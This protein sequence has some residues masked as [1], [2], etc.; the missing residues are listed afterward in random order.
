V[1]RALVKS[2]NA[3]AKGSIKDVAQAE[4]ISLAEAFLGADYVVLLDV[5]GSMG[6]RDAGNEGREKRHDVAER[7]LRNLQEKYPG[8]LALVCFS[9]DVKFC[10]AGVPDRMDLLTDVAAAL[11]FVHAVDETVEF[12]LISDGAPNNERE[13]LEEAEKFKSAIHTIYIGPDW[14]YAGKEFLSRISK[15]SGGRNVNASKI[16]ELTSPLEKILLLQAKES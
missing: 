1:N 11:R 15:V 6:E 5:S 7:E 13:A 4:G 2:D 10:P 3:L 8:K 14:D 16:A 12:F 9:T